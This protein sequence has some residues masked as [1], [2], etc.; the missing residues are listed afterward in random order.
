MVR[1]PDF[2]KH[3]PRLSTTVCAS[4]PISMTTILSRQVLQKYL[5]LFKLRSHW[6]PPKRMGLPEAHPVTLVI[7][8]SGQIWHFS[9]ENPI[10]Q[11]HFPVSGSQSDF[12]D[13]ISEHL[14]SVQKKNKRYSEFKCFIKAYLFLRCDNCSLI[15][16]VF[17]GRFCKKSKKKSIKNV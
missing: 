8:P 12:W 11:L 7:V 15:L 4:M 9:P 3:C 5:F 13:P 10:L 6:N 2:G 14:H 16:T 1:G 17:L